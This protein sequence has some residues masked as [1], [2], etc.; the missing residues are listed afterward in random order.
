MLEPLEPLSRLEAKL[1]REQ[2]PPLLI[3]VESLRLAP[4]AVEGEH[5]LGSEALTQRVLA[6]EHANLGDELRVPAQREVGIEP[7]LDGA[8]TELSE[9]AALDLHESNR[10]E[11]GKRLAAPEVE[12]L[13][14][15]R[16]CAVRLARSERSRALGNERLEPPKVHRRRSRLEDVARR[17][18]EDEVG[19]K[20][21]PQGR[22]VTLKRRV[23]GLGSALAP[24]GVDQAVAR[25]D[26]I[27]A[28]EEHGKN[29]SLFCP[30]ERQRPACPLDLERTE[31]P[32]LHSILLRGTRP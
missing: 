9:S 7:L 13:A 3:D 27:R 24:D 32:K 6:D 17:A 31:N 11:I 10:V 4:R 8:Q 20:R 23:G 12:C 14:Q 1:L 22:D 2:A 30:A 29:G 16:R 28:Q 5:Q 25:D 18:C 26:A 15:P 21:L 19:A